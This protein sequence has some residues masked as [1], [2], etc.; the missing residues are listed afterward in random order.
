MTK[1]NEESGIYV[2][3]KIKGHKIVQN[4]MAYTRGDVSNENLQKVRNSVQKELAS[5]RSVQK[6]LLSDFD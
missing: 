6:P 5:L 4:I 1:V 3:N 2:A